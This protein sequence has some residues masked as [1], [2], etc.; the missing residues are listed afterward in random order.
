[1]N[2][3]QILWVLLVGLLVLSLLSPFS[4]LSLSLLFLLGGTVIWVGGTLLGA[5]RGSSDPETDR[6][7]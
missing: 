6:E 1:M 4:A 7:S 3:N 2:S 5:I